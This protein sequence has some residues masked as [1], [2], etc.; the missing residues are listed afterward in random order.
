MSDQ[1]TLMSQLI[2]KAMLDI[3]GQNI[4]V[5]LDIAIDDDKLRRTLAPLFP[6]AANARFERKEEGDT[7]MVQVIKQLGTKG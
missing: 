5:P 3:E 6:G 4:A 7:L 2:T 1:L